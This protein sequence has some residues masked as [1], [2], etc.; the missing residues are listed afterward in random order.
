MSDDERAGR[1]STGLR[2]PAASFVVIL[3]C[4]RPVGSDLPPPA[5][6]SRDRG[7]AMKEIDRAL[8]IDPSNEIFYY[9]AGGVTQ[10][11]ET[12]TVGLATNSRRW[13]P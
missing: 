2:E 6:R 10:G 11:S 3:C 7:T 1:R 12:T 4:A 9:R 13:T 8:E 5:P